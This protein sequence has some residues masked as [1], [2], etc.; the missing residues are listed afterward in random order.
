MPPATGLQVLEVILVTVVGGAGLVKRFH[1]A[2]SIRCL[3]RSVAPAPTAVP[4]HVST[5]R[6]QNIAPAVLARPRPRQLA[7]PKEGCHVALGHMDRAALRAADHG[8]RHAESSRELG[9]REPRLLA[10][11]LQR[12][13]DG[14]MGEGDRI[15]HLRV[16][17]CQRAKARV[18]RARNDGVFGLGQLAHGSV[19]VSIS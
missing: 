4:S 19:I 11:S 1:G 8:L 7:G 13:G 17:S 14:P 16:H 6:R 5:A 18:L 9:L 12:L 15:D 2:E 10:R 3:P